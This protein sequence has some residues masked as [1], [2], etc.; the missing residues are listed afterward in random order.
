MGCNMKDRLQ[1]K[2]LYLKERHGIVGVK[3]GT[4]VED[5]TFEELKVLK[6]ISEG[7]VPMI[8]K[9]GGPEARN[10]MRFCYNNKIDGILAPMVESEYAFHNFMQSVKEIVENPKEYFL[11]VNLETIT[12]Y[13]NLNSIILHPDFEYIDQITVGRSDLAGSMELHVNNDEVM[14]VAADIVERVRQKDKAT[15]VGGKV[16]TYNAQLIRNKINP[17][18]VNTRH[19]SLD[20]QK[21][22]NLEFSICEALNFEI[23]LYKIFIQ[24]N[25]DRTGMYSKRIEDTKQRMMAKQEE[26]APSIGLTV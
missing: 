6:E 1:R 7:I 23:D 18:K 10:D 15:S 4:E 16:D 21:S 20:F 22:K 5:M 24:M 26:K 19:V 13:F 8:V 25:P 2:L 12:S 11:A 14:K 9:I 17:D 3:G